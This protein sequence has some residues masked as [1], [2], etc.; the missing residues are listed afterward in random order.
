MQF[1]CK[2]VFRGDENPPS[3]FGNVN[4]SFCGVL[5]AN[6]QAGHGVPQL[7]TQQ[8]LPLPHVAP[9][10]ILLHG[11]AHAVVDGRNLFDS[12]LLVRFVSADTAAADEGP[13]GGRQRADGVVFKRQEQCF[14]IFHPGGLPILV[15]VQW[16]KLLQAGKSRQQRVG[17]R[18]LHVA[19]SP[20]LQ[21]CVQHG[22]VQPGRAVDGDRWSSGELSARR[23]LNQNAAAN[24]FPP[25]V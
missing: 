9:Q 23:F 16:S 25:D 14:E 11:P 2:V 8:C 19:V 4:P 22:E 21:P 6:P 18:T 1:L 10:K 13:A 15:N 12:Q 3:G 20:P 7:N 17:H 24:T 5:R